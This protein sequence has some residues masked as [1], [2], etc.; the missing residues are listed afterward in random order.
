MKT[1]PAI[2]FSRWLILVAILVVGCRRK[3]SPTSFKSD[4]AN[5]TDVLPQT[6]RANTGTS[7]PNQWTYLPIGRTE[8]GDFVAVCVMLSSF[9][10]GYSQLEGQQ[11][12]DATRELLRLRG[13]LGRRI[14]LNS[15]VVVAQIEG[16]ITKELARRLTDKSLS[17]KAVNNV[18]EG[19]LKPVFTRAQ[20]LDLVGYGANP[21]K[22]SVE[23]LSNFAYAASGGEK[24]LLDDASRKTEDAYFVRTKKSFWKVTLICKAR[25]AAAPL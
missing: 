20:F 22:L 25:L 17:L 4:S 10:A 21:K 14:Q 19:Y 12:F 2:L 15:Y 11:F 1:S 6:L 23:E 3:E 8:I 5:E 9:Q 24:G 18:A 7:V 16:M 13:E